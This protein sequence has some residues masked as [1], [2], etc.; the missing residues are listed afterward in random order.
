MQQTAKRE[1]IGGTLPFNVTTI[2]NIRKLLPLFIAALF[3]MNSHADNRPMGAHIFG[4]ATSFNDSTVYLTEIQYVDSAYIGKS[5]FLFSR[6][7]YSYQLQNYLKS[8]GIATPT[9]VT[10]FAKKQ[11]NIEK[12]YLKMR[13]RYEKKGTYQIKFIPL[14]DFLYKGIAPQESDLNREKIA[15]QKAKAEMKETKKAKKEAKL[16]RKEAARQAATQTTK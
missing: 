8:K 3:A 11:K 7:N 1:M 10:T 9:C 13:K 2:M 12:K 4:F 16:K 15:K 5:N 14:Q 6:E